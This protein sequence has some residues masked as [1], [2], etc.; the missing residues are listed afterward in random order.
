MASNPQNLIGHSFK[1][2]TAERQREI[3]SMGGKASQ[4]AAAERKSLAKIARAVLES[5]VTDVSEYNYGAV[6]IDKPTLEAII[7]AVHGNKAAKGD[8]Q[9]AKFLVET[10]ERELK[11]DNDGAFQFITEQGDEAL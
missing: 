7:F 9:S 4:R 1:D 5:Q 2:M 8:V 11:S 6:P 3:A 10:A